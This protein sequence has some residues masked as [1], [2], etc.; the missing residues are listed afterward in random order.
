[1]T[2]HEAQNPRTGS[3]QMT[4]LRQLRLV[5]GLRQSDLAERAGVSRETIRLLETGD[6]MPRLDTA[7]RIA[8]A[9]DLGE[10]SAA[11][12]ELLE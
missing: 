11:F 3:G 2:L 10:A 12:P 1:M 9:L 4:R 8:I 5:A 7:H 6:H